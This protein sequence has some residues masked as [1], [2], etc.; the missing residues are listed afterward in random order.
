VDGC[1]RIVQGE[2]VGRG[3]EVFQQGFLEGAGFEA[4]EGTGLRAV[5][6]R[7]VREE[8]ARRAKEEDW[9]RRGTD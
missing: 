6:G 1:G 7:R 3:G 5:R 2:G 4:E 9:R 8:E